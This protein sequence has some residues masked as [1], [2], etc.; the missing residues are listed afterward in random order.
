M[1]KVT[2][3]V[4]RWS[5]ARRLIRQNRDVLR[6]I[7]IGRIL[8]WSLVGS[9]VICAVFKVMCPEVELLRWLWPLPFLVVAMFLWFGFAGIYLPVLIP[10]LITVSGDEIRYSHGDQEGWIAAREDCTSFKIVVYSQTIR[11]MKFRHKEKQRSI[12]LAASVDVDQLRSLLPYPVKMVDSRRR[13]AYFQKSWSAA[14]R[15]G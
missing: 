8:L 13:F 2:W 6:R 1:G 12:G 11:R 9:L 7:S 5:Y 14:R 15:V 10:P 4:P 3:W